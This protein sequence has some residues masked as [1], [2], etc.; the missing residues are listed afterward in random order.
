MPNDIFSIA[1]SCDN[2]RAFI[3]DYGGDIK[4]IKWQA[5]ASS[6][7]DFDFTEKPIRLDISCTSK[8]CLTKDE[9]YLLV[10]SRT[11]VSVFEIESRKVT[12]EFNIMTFVVDIILIQDYKKAIIA[13]GNG[14]L[15]IL[16]LETL[17]ISSVAEKVTNGKHLSKMIVI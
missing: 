4:I 7:D 15:T 5:G 16:N 11:L 9:K 2:Q 17:E 10:G 13:E 1:F 8:I 12:K 3:S 6:W 14:N